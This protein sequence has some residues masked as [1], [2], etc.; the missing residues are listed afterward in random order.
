MRALPLH[1]VQSL[2]EVVAGSLAERRL[3]LQLAGTSATLSLVLAALALWGAVAQNV[4]DRR[5]EL[6][7][8]LALG[9]TE[10]RAVGLVVRR[11]VVLIVAG[12]LL[13]LLAAGLSARGLGHTL[14]GV[15]PLDPLTFAAAICAALA[16]SLLACYLPAR[17]AAAISPA[18]L[19]REG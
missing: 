16:V 11:G 7:I 5:R 8:R 19:L 4:F 13:G 10:S 1:P 14:H 18:E 17:R 3:R 9:A 12:I 2:E 6:G 15:A